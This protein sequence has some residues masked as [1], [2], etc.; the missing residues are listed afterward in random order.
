VQWLGVAGT[1]R[2][3]TVSLDAMNDAQVFELTITYDE[4]VLRA[5]AV[6][7]FWRHWKSKLRMTIGSVVALLC[8]AGM[9]IYFQFFSFLWWIALY[10]VVLFVLWVYIRWATER[11]ILKLLG[12]SL[13]VR[14]TQVDFTVMSEGDSHTFLWKR[15]N[16]S[17]LDSESLYLFVTRSI[18]YILPIRQAGKPAIDFARAQVAASSNR[19]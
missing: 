14:M 5:A 19:A 8:A 12:K 6:V 13:K 3:S 15:F 17:Q 11:R 7:L 9:F 1:A 4:V 16:S 2:R 18:A 10:L